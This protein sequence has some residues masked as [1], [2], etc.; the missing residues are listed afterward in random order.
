LGLRKNSEHT[1]G[2][3]ACCPLAPQNSEPAARGDDGA[4]AHFVEQPT[5]TMENSEEGF[6]AVRRGGRRELAAMDREEG[7]WAAMEGRELPPLP[8]GRR[9]ASMEEERGRWE[10]DGAVALCR[11]AAGHRPWSKELA[12]GCCRREQGG[13]RGAMHGV[14][15]TQGALVARDRG[16]RELR[17]KG[18]RAQGSSDALAAG[19]EEASVCNRGREP[20]KGRGPAMAASTP[21]K[22]GP[23]WTPWA[24]A[25]LWGG[26][27]PWREGAGEGGAAAARGRNREKREWR[28]KI[29]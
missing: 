15:C 12:G 29:F 19:R 24:G 13:R 9:S 26:C 20:E 28:L 8:S 14:C 23:G 6:T 2:I 11:A 4:S 22:G 5:G 21:C 1:A 17:R 27:S 7:S 3:T 25:W 16:R 10:G 18:R